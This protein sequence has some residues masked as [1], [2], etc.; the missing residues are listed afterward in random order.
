MDATCLGGAGTRTV[1]QPA[2]LAGPS[3]AWRV[4]CAVHAPQRGRQLSPSCL[5]PAFPQGPAASCY[6]VGHN[7]CAHMLRL[8]PSGPRA[9]RRSVSAHQAA[10]AA[11]LAASHLVHSHSLLTAAVQHL[12]RG[13]SFPCWSPALAT[14]VTLASITVTT[15]SRLRAAPVVSTSNGRQARRSF[16][17]AR[18]RPVV[19]T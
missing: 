3:A 15:A 11:L 12:H 14:A 8:T 13:R 2:T 5:A 7:G 6:L 9:S 19:R 16:T 18:T 17:H 1:S 4:L 10:A